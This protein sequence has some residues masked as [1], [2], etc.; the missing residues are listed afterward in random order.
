ML[1]LL[2]TGCAATGAAASGSSNGPPEPAPDVAQAAAPASAVQDAAAGDPEAASRVPDPAGPWIV[3]RGKAGPGV[4]RH[5]VLVS[6]DEEYRSEETLPQLA[7]LLAEHHGFTCTVLFAVDEQGLID[8][9][10]NDN[11]P[12]LSA[13]DDADLM[14][15]FTR[16]RDLPDEQMAP[17]ARY[18][19]RGGPLLA[20][21]TSTHAFALSAESSYA[22]WTWNSSA[23]GWEGGFGRQV[24][25]ETWIAH[26]GRHGVQGTRGLIAPGASGHPVLAGLAD[27][28]V[29]GATDVY[30][31]R[32]PLPEGCTPLVL[33]QVLQGLTPG[34]APASG[35]Q[36]D[37]LMPVVWCRE[38]APGSGRPRRLVTTTLGASQDLAF[39]GTRRLLV[40]AVFW[41]LGLEPP[42]RAE[43]GLVGRFEPTP[44]AFG[45]AREGLRPS[46]LAWPP[47]AR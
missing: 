45:G 31:V 43:V 14:V 25:G 21:R 8:P 4:G 13:L 39:E 10:V 34:A 42:T 3:V 47:R 18:I 5:I 1:P 20:L 40:N 44:F 33:G 15:L 19:E 24:L 11:I 38:S 28:D 26:H 17:I 32:L 46:D 22:H 29:F 2:M 23:P 6:G 35:A 9:D 41:G 7:R 12:G 30:R 36:N 27:G 37:P 16:F